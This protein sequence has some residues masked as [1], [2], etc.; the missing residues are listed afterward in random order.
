MGE[1]KPLITIVGI[2][3]KQGRSA[4]NTLLKDGRFRV[5]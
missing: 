2:L 1:D 3:G 5:R 4:A